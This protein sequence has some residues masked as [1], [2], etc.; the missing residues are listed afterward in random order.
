M[1][2]QKVN[3]KANLQS[4]TA[5]VRSVDWKAVDEHHARK[6]IEEVLPLFEP[7]DNRFEFSIGPFKCA[8][9]PALGLHCHKDSETL[10]N[11]RMLNVAK[12]S[13]DYVIGKAKE[14]IICGIKAHKLSS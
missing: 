10:G 9:F 6:F 3:T 12:L 1:Q 5:K 11:T 14:L 8:E 7:L 4:F 13:V 2:V